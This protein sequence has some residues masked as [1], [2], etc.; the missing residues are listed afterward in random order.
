MSSSPLP[1]RGTLL[2]KM[3]RLMTGAAHEAA[4][5][6]ITL[7]ELARLINAPLPG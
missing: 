2:Y 1:E 3:V 6:K 4:R 5:G 7:E